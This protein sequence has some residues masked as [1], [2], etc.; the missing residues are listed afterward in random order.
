MY[1]DL[2][3][4]NEIIINR[5]DKTKLCKSCYK[6]YLKQI[7]HGKTTTLGSCAKKLEWYYA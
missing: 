6:H 4:T 1:Q 2:C 3:P 5:R 7:K